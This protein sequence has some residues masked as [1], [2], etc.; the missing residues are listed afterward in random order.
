[1]FGKNS[2]VW[3][4]HPKPEVFASRISVDGARF[5]RSAKLVW[6]RLWSSDQFWPVFSYPDIH[7]YPLRSY[8]HTQKIH[9]YYIEISMEI[10]W[11]TTGFSNA[12]GGTGSASLEHH[13]DQ[14]E[15]IWYK[16]YQHMYYIYIYMYM[17]YVPEL[18]SWYTSYSGTVGKHVL[19]I[20]TS[21]YSLAEDFI[22]LHPSIRMPKSWTNRGAESPSAAV[23]S[24][25]STDRLSPAA[26]VSPGC[27][28]KGAEK[29]RCHD[30][31]MH[32]V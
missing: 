7:W 4:V 30:G 29:K 15:D 1:M 17:I 31:N 5:S 12:S 10:L 24:A 22:D 8:H 19:I 11:K 16:L 13:H 25:D 14:T 28:H 9:K 23:E 26:V 2:N 21:N 20:L 6:C 27:S 3:I 32:Y 18:K